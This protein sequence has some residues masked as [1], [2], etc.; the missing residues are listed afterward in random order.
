VPPPASTLLALP[1]R[2]D[3]LVFAL[4]AVTALAGSGRRMTAWAAPPLA[5][6]AARLPGVEAVIDGELPGLGGWGEA[7]LL[8]AER[9]T[10]WTLWRAGIPLRW[11]YGGRAWGGPLRRALLA[12]AVPGPSR[13]SLGERHASEDFRELLAVLGLELPSGAAPRLPIADD[14]VAAAEERLARAHLDPR[15]RPRVGLIPGGR[16]GEEGGRRGRRHEDPAGRWPWQSFAELLQ[17]L[18]RRTNGL[19]GVLLAGREDLWPAVR[20]HEET[21]RL[22]PLIGPDLD[23]AGLAGLLARLDLVVA[24]DSELLQLAAATGVATLALFGPTDPRRRAPRG[25][26]HRRLI[27]SGGDLRELAVGEVLAVCE[28]LLP[29]PRP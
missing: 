21:A 18:R 14:L 17:R 12:P 29:G 28:E 25:S 2:L 27:A 7:V 3:E 15:G 1:R 13:R 20:I 8:T 6:L 16:L 23:A 19:S 24:A 11:G 5:P 4:P 22:H 26:Q 10:A 9:G